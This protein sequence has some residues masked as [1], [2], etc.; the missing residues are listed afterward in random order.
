MNQRTADST[1]FAKSN[2]TM[3]NLSGVVASRVGNREY[4]TD[5]RTP[6]QLIK[7]KRKSIRSEHLSLDSV[8]PWQPVRCQAVPFAARL[9]S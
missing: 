9:I 8:Q 4:D 7:P 6:Y 2:N 1:V 3:K 5:E